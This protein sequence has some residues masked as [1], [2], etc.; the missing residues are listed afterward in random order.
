MKISS[1]LAIAMTLAVFIPRA[2]AEE[3][4]TQLWI[5]SY[6]SPVE[7]SIDFGNFV[8]IDGPDRI[9]VAGDVETSHELLLLQ[10]DADGNLEWERRYEG[11]SIAD[12]TDLDIPSPGEV[13]I[14]GYVLGS[15]GAEVATV[16]YDHLGNLMWDRRRPLVGFDSENGPRLASDGDG[17]LLVSATDDGDYLALKYAPDGTLLWSRNYDGP[18]GD[19]DIATD[20]AADETGEVYLTGVADMF[21]AYATVKFSRDGDFLWDQFESGEFGSVFPPSRV[22]IAPDHDLVVAGTPESFCGVFQFKIWKCSAATGAVLWSDKAPSDPC[23]SLT[24]RDMAIH[25]SGDIA[26]LCDGTPNGAEYHL[27][28]FRY[29][30]G[31]TRMWVREFDGEGIAES[32]ASAITVDA[33]GSVYAVGH[34]APNPQ[35]WDYLAVKYSS[36]GNLE[37]AVSWDSEDERQDSVGDVAVEPT[38]D[39]ILTGSS[40]KLLEGLNV[41]TIKYHQA[42]SAEVGDL[43]QVSLPVLRLD[44]SP[45]PASRGTMIGYTLPKDGAARLEIVSP[46]GRRVRTVAD[47]LH[48]AGRHTIR[49][50]GT[51]AHGARLPSGIYLAHLAAGG[52]VISAKIHLLP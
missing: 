27:Q 26:A 18:A 14:V 45:N 30:G 29:T 50:D 13:A 47:G 41:V 22:A 11:G 51:D 44:L 46:E 6:D 16:K 49:W 28:V 10:Y 9:Y 48:T 42:S 39:V 15:N 23:F 24:F 21:V 33:A 8:A 3:P 2:R 37:W 31:G 19:Y 4:P 5:E 52:S 36:A 38:G 20:I 12:L 35:N 43:A 7:D 1:L 34:A 25:S 32:F 40:T 17:N